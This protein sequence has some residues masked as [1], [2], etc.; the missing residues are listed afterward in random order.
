LAKPR[1]ILKSTGAEDIASAG[2]NGCSAVEWQAPGK[3]SLKPS[4]SG[5]R[6]APDQNHFLV[7]CDHDG[8]KENVG[9]TMTGLPDDLKNECQAVYDRFLKK[10]SL[11]EWSINVKIVD[12]TQHKQTL[13]IDFGEGG[14]S[15]LKR[16][17][18]TPSS[19][20]EV[21]RN[22]DRLLES[23]YQTYLCQKKRSASSGE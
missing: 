15:W 22:I 23:N 12:K 21:R 4:G 5:V 8:M 3:P 2:E 16:E 20:A 13:V 11:S 1:D 10:Y 14:P 18:I 17:K 6:D 19:D 7:L 9:L